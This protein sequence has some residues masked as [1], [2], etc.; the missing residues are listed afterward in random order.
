MDAHNRQIMGNH[1]TNYG[2][3][4]IYVDFTYVTF[5]HTMKYIGSRKEKHEVVMVQKVNR[6]NNSQ[7]QLQQ[8]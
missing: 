8:H 1:Q 6:F 2:E 5:E 7:L 3:P 4:L